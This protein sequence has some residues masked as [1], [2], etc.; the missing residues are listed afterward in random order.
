MYPYEGMYQKDSGQYSVKKYTGYGCGAGVMVKKDFF[1]DIGGF[2]EYYFG[3]GEELELGMRA[4]QYGY[5]VLYLPEAIVFHERNRT[6]KDVTYFGTS[7]SV[8]NMFYFTLKN[9]EWSHVF[10]YL[11]EGIFLALIPKLIFFTATGDPKR[12]IAAM[13]GIYW[14]LRDAARKNILKRVFE[15]RKA[16]RKNK[17]RGDKELFQLGLM[18]DFAE[19]SIYR[20]KVA[21]ARLRYD[22]A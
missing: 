9:Y 13:R 14:F 10:Q 12:S 11:F 19:R 21:K 2:D 18:S 16:I 8:R 22:R 3:G 7:V 15:Q 5:K 1:L 6:F 4:W 20:L 17:K